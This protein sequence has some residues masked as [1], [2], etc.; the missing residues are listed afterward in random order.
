MNEFEEQPADLHQNVCTAS[1]SVEWTHGDVWYGT[2][3]TS[4]VSFRFVRILFVILCMIIICCIHIRLL[5]YV[6]FV[7]F[8]HFCSWILFS[9]SIKWK[10]RVIRTKTCTF[11]VDLVHNIPMNEPLCNTIRTAHYF[12]C[13]Y[14][15]C[16]SA[17]QYVYEY[18]VRSDWCGKS[19]LMPQMV[20]V[21]IF[22]VEW[23]IQIIK[24]CFVIVL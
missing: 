13:P 20:C 2:K 23:H 22:Q 12:R 4:S 7:R 11:D 6:R 14:F 21:Y 17:S 18:F 24:H 15:T 19:M 16:A 8:T 9:K 5:T 10:Y 1:S 3:V